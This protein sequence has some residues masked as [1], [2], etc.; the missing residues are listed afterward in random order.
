MPESYLCYTPHGELGEVVP[1]PALA[2]GHVT[3]GCY[4]NLSKVSSATIRCWAKV[5]LAVPNSRLVLRYA[6]EQQSRMAERIAEQ[7]AGLG[8]GGDRLEF[9]PRTDDF[10]QHMKGFQKIDIAL[11]PFPYVGTTTTCDTLS[12]GVPV[13]TLKGDRFIA[14][15]GESILHNVGLEDWIAASQEEYVAKAAAFAADLPGLANLRAN[16]RQKFF[17]SPVCDAPRFARNLEAAFA[18]MWRAW[19]ERQAAVRPA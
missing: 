12:M 11:D 5:L 9:S 6:P 17:L 2:A 14:H 7:F 1:P 19:C 8:I 10:A 13:L 4:N 18:G 3:F 16:L 15:V